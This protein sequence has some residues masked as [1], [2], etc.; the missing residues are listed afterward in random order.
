[1]NKC[2]KCGIYV[3][4][5]EDVMQ[6]SRTVSTFCT[7]KTSTSLSN[8]VKSWLRKVMTCLGSTSLDMVVKPARRG[9]SR[10]K[11]DLRRKETEMISIYLF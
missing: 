11:A 3:K 9:A 5:S 4:Y 7:P 8:F 2:D 10:D 1:V 6:Q